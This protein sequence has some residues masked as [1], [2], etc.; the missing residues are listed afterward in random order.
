MKRILITSDGS[1]SSAEALALGLELAQEQATPVTLVHVI[2][3]NDLQRGPAFEHPEQDEVLRE[4][5]AAA[6]KIGVEPELKLLSGDVADEI[7]WLAEHI[8]ADLVFIGS[9]GL[10]KLQGTLLGSVSRA[11]LAKCT[12]PV[13]V[14]RDSQVAAAV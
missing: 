9:R 13:V 4:A 8:E 2:P 6:R 5:A 3:K 14:V 11:V 12:R 10:G 7:A 1:P